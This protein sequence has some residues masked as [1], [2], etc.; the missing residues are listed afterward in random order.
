VVMV[1]IDAEPAGQKRMEGLLQEHHV[2]FPVLK[3]RFNLVAR[4]WLGMQSP[5]P[6]LF[7]VRP[8]GTVLRVHRGYDE[9][10]SGQLAAEVAS[11]LGAEQPALAAD[12]A[13]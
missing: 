2:T 12:D 5:L 1:S 8:D 9:K 6:S 13:P 3:D 10:T 11:A 7:F 4:R